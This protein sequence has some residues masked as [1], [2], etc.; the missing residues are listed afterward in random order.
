M[1][2][3]YP[4]GPYGIGWLLKMKR[5][6]KNQPILKIVGA[7]CQ[8]RNE[9]QWLGKVKGFQYNT[10]GVCEVIIEILIHNFSY[11]D[12]RNTEKPELYTYPLVNNDIQNVNGAWVLFT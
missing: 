9:F 11:G 2:T 6:L 3:Y 4:F 1:H 5:N 12:N 8:G 10:E 7:G